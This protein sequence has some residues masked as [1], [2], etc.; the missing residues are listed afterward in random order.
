[1][2][3]VSFFLPD[4]APRPSGAPSDLELMFDVAR[5]IAFMPL[6]EREAKVRE[7]AEAGGA[8]L[9][10]ETH[11]EL[12]RTHAHAALITATT[13]KACDRLREAINAYS[14]SPIGG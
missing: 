11:A 10:L 6:A 2:T 4:A 12:V 1:V 7:M 13:R 9:I 5:E 3:P 8:D 14:A